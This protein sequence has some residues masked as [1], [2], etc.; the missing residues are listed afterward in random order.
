MHQNKD[1]NGEGFTST[2]VQSKEK[3]GLGDPTEQHVGKNEESTQQ[4][5][6]RVERQLSSQSHVD[7]L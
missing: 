6:L 2:A 5:S 7:L 4:V 3:T 1:G